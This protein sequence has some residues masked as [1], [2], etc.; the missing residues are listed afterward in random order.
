MEEIIERALKYVKNKNYFNIRE[1]V[2]AIMF[3]RNTNCFFEL[4]N[5]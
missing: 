4:L 5:T 2:N 1:L 3:V